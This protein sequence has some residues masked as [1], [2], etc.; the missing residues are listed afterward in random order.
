[1]GRKTPESFLAT[2]MSNF[3]FENYNNIPFRFDIGADVPLPIQIA[4]RAKELHG[5]WS[6]GYPDMLI[7]TC[8]KGYG[9]L[10]LELKATE[11][12]ADTEHTRTQSLYHAVLRKNGY[13]C[14]FCCGYEECTKYIKKYLKRKK[15]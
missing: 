7:A 2:R 3:M 12:V 15:K 13:K 5:K 8:R 10:Y 11:V 1:M 9:G 14:V 6:R 4:K